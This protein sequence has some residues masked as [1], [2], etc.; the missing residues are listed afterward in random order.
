MTWI[1]TDHDL[2]VATNAWSPLLDRRQ[3]N[4]AETWLKSSFVNHHNT[5]PSIFRQPPSKDVDAAW[6]SIHKNARNFLITEDEVR[7]LGKDPEYTVM[8]P[9]EWQNGEEKYFALT[10]VQHD[11][12]CLNMV[13]MSMFPDYYFPEGRGWGGEQHFLHCLHALLQSLRCKYST[14]V[15]LASWVEES[16][17]PVV[18]FNVSRKCLN[19]EHDVNSWKPET[20]R[21][22]AEFFG[23]RAPEWAKFRPAEI[24]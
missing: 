10:Q 11:L 8:A 19:Y 22:D 4:F 15:Y 1:P 6:E 23:L 24:V 5:P 9:E 14:D 7:R 13:R 18:D 2:V 20:Q 21:T 12:H 16:D 17:F 3:M